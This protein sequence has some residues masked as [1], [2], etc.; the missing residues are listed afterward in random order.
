MQRILN[1]VPILVM[2]CL[3]GCNPTSTAFDNE[4]GVDIHIYVTARSKNN[5]AFGLLTAGIRL[6]LH[7]R[8]EDIEIVKYSYSDHRCILTHDQLRAAAVRAKYGAVYI[9]KLRP[10]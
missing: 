1:I 3:Q 9:V 10:C 6:V 5:D 4:T 2:S 8:I 7:D